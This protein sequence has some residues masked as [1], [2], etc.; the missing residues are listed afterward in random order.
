MIWLICIYSKLNNIYRRKNIDIETKTLR[1]N[2][3][4]NYYITF[5]QP[6]ENHAISDFAERG[7][8]TNGAGKDGQEFSL[9]QMSN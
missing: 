2:I 7:K 5:L 9:S 3:Y 8:Q 1:A 6:L 4:E